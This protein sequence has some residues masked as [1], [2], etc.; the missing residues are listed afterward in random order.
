LERGGRGDDD[1][2]D[3]DDDHV[4]DDRLFIAKKMEVGSGNKTVT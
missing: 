4:V 3:D 1:D 2:D